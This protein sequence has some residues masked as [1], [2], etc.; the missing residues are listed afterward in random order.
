MINIPT[1]LDNKLVRAI[2]L[3]IAIIILAYKILGSFSIFVLPKESNLKVWDAFWYESIRDYGYLLI[4][5][6]QCNLAFFPLFPYLWR[7]LNVSSRG[8][9]LINFIF[10]FLA[11][12]HLFKW[13]NLPFHLTLILLSIPSLVFMALPY[14]ECIF[15]VFGTCLLLGYQGSGSK[16]FILGVIGCSLTRSV[17]IIFIPAFLLTFFLLGEYNTRKIKTLIYALIASAVSVGAVVFLQWIQT[18]EL[19]YFMK[20]QKYWR[21]HFEWP[22]LPFS[23]SSGDQIAGIDGISLFLGLISIMFLIKLFFER[24]INRHKNKSVYQIN[25][26]VIFSLLYVS[27]TLAVNTFFSFNIGDGTVL[28]SLN[29]HMLATPFALYLI[30]WFL[31]EYKLSHRD[32]FVVGICFLLCLVSTR[33][34]YFQL[35][36]LYL[37]LAV[38]LFISYKYPSVLGSRLVFLFYTLQCIIQITCFNLILQG[39]WIA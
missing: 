6:Q 19:F 24:A 11:F 13:K 23:A 31:A 26:A 20:V 38:L 10:F 22:S 4:P 28:M 9:S 36:L 21:R 17:S 35:Q 39:Y 25:S 2:I 3:H 33:I 14:S 37:I 12:Y 8:I 5:N 32:L 18:G 34:Y 29:R 15:F 27:A 16:L 7:I 30:Y 1:L